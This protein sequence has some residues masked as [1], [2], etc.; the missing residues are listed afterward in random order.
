M[1]LLLFVLLSYAEPPQ[2]P[3]EEADY[4]VSLNLRTGGSLPVTSSLTNNLNYLSTRAEHIA[5]QG[6]SDDG[7]TL[8]RFE[9]YPTGDKDQIFSQTLSSM[10]MNPSNYKRVE[11]GGSQL[12]PTIE[13]YRI[14]ERTS[15][16]DHLMAVGNRSES[17]M[18]ILFFLIGP[19]DG[20]YMHTPRFA[21]MV[22]NYRPAPKML[23]G[24]GTAIGAWSVGLSVTLLV[25]NLF[26]IWLGFMEIARTGT[27]ID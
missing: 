7:R 24:S 11:Q 12:S 4:F 3:V 21:S 27:A 13:I 1:P 14:E 15:Y 22:E 18:V 16:Q 23:L 6:H 5:I 2:E 19:R 20:F 26:F 8:F 25:V 17:G 9:F 10:G